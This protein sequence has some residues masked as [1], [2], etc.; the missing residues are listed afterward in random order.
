MDENRRRKS[1]FLLVV[2]E[3]ASWLVDASFAEPNSRIDPAV[4]FE[5]RML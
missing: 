2:I 5:N 1:V 4:S 3:T